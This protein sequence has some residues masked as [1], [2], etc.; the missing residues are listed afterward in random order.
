[1]K[2]LIS[3]IIIGLVLGVSTNA[4]AAVGDSVTA[5]FTQFSYKVN[6]EIKTLD[7]PVLVH[8]GNSY[9]RTTQISNML[10]FDVTYKADSR[11]IEFNKP[12]PSPELTPTASSAPNE[13]QG[14]KPNGTITPSYD[15]TSSPSESSQPSPSP[16]TD[17]EPST[18]PDNTAICKAIRDEY[19]S[20]IAGLWYQD[21]KDSQKKIRKLELEHERNQK[22]SAAGC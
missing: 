6:G 21:I 8:D 16:T 11:T 3:G 13:G 1:M 5:V 7:S 20:K 12:E 19:E 10:G 17:P 18:T 4:F 9:L 2:K 15:P 22:L 14:T